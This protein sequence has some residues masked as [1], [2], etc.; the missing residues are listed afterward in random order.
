[1]LTVRVT[2]FERVE[3]VKVPLSVETGVGF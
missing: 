3:A 2:Y 1:V